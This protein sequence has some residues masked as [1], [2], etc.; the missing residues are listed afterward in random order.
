[1]F[2]GT[3]PA[4]LAEVLEGRADVA[5]VSISGSSEEHVENAL[6]L[7]A[8]RAGSRDLS[9]LAITNAAPTDA[10]VLTRSLDPA[11]HDALVARLSPVDATA[12][13]VSSLCLAMEAEGFERAREG[14]Y[15]PILA[16]LD[17][18]G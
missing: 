3:H 8:G 13:R 16:L 10:L 14:E 15:A 6:E 17:D 9:A 11:T 12:G 18:D 2:L 5:A 1:M 4:A 7:H